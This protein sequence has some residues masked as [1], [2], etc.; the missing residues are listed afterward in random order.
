MNIYIYRYIYIYIDTQIYRE[1][2]YKGCV[3]CLHSLSIYIYIYPTQMLL[4]KLYL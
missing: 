4:Y 3:M 1:T 2:L